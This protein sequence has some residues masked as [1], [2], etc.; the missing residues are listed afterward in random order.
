MHSSPSDLSP[1]TRVSLEDLRDAWPV[2]DPADRVDGFRF[3]RSS[4]ADEF[5][6]ALD[7]Y[8]QAGLVR[9]LPPAEQRLWLRVLAPDDAADL[10]QEL[11]EAERPALLAQ[12]DPQTRQEVGALLAYEE[13]EAGG[14]M[15]PR[16]ARL[17]PAWSVDEATAY[18][19]RQTRRQVEG[20]Y[21]AY[22]V[23]EGERLLGT[24]SFR[25][26]ITARGDARVREVM[27]TELV[28]VR[29][30][31]DQEELSRLFAEVD[32]LALPVVDAEGRMQGI[33]T[34]D[35]IVDVVTE[36]A[37]EDIQ[38]IGGSDPLEAPYLQTSFG[39]MFRKRA[40]WLTVLFL[41]GMLTVTAMSAFED[42]LYGVLILFVPLIISTGGNCGSQASTLVIRAMA[43]NEVRL[44]DW[45]VVMRRE[46]LSGAALGVMLG[47]L[48]LLRA[49]FGRFALGEGAGHESDFVRI[50]ATLTIAV[51]G[52]TLW[53]TLAGALLPF[54]LKRLGFDPASASAPLVATVV[55]VTGLL[56]YFGVA[57]AL[58]QGPAF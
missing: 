19:R 34:A 21:Y 37:T 39:Q 1:T 57:S 51:L 24:V 2:L 13:D 7:A 6:L 33:V 48:G 32:L 54:G 23:D 8:D 17:R 14:L 27:K 30:E 20:V 40:G 42:R 58:L 44:R 46:L 31:L 10:I 49:V 43:L 22:V 11:P 18:L 5:F 55:D 41:G 26:L 16:Y 38:K 3:L 35:D 4:E 52:V 12:L 56:I 25:E 45:W 9:L 47:L 29:E 28:T 50:C 53:G 15:N 36:E